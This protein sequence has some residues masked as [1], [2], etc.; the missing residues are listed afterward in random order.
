MTWEPRSPP[1]ATP[2]P[3]SRS[4][5]KPSNWIPRCPKPAA[6]WRWSWKTSRA[7]CAPKRPCLL[8]GLRLSRPLSRSAPCFDED[9][10][11]YLK[12]A[13]AV[14]GIEPFQ[15]IKPKHL[16]QFCTIRVGSQAAHR[17]CRNQE[18]VEIMHNFAQEG[19]KTAKQSHS[20]A[21]APNP[22]SRQPKA[23][24]GGGLASFVQNRCAP[25]THSQQTT[26]KRANPP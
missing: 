25:V 20:Q 13:C 4:S 9:G 21:L 17:S 22:C 26:W 19:S 8:N 12:P 3:P 16:A 24:P 18:K 1:A 11:H 23:G 2:A 6:T 10:G 14:H 7:S 15:I 5:A